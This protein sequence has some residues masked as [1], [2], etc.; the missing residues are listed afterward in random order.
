MRYDR[1]DG[2]IGYK[3]IEII[4]RRS[5][6][7]FTHLS[8]LRDRA[9]DVK[10]TNRVSVHRYKSQKLKNRSPC[11]IIAHAKREELS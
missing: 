8:G 2:S 3:K 1:T 6:N 5:I 7:T 9:V 11:N 10:Q 4:T